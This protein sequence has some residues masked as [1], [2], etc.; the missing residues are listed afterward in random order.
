MGKL[1]QYNLG[2]KLEWDVSEMDASG[3]ACRGTLTNTYLECQPWSDGHRSGYY[4]TVAGKR[5]SETL[6]ELPDGAMA[7]AYAHYVKAHPVLAPKDMEELIAP[8]MRYSHINVCGFIDT[9]LGV[10][11][12]AWGRAYQE[13]FYKDI[14]YALRAHP[15]RLSVNKV[16]ESPTGTTWYTVHV[17][18]VY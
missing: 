14:L 2:A 13:E 7:E 11:F 4:A 17:S 15:V 16:F 1:Q 8:T 9:H 10:T 12:S 3:Y 5:V 18:W 6:H